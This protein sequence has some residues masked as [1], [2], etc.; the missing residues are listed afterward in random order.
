MTPLP[1]IR[2]FIV[3]GAR[4][5]AGLTPVTSE[6]VRAL[7]RI[8]VRAVGMKPVARGIIA[9]G[10]RWQ[11]D[12]L[13]QLAAAS[14]FGLPTRVLCSH[15]RRPDEPVPA[16]PDAPPTLDTVVD[17]FRVLSTWADTVVVDGADGLSFGA[18]DLARALALPF[19]FVVG[20][21]SGSSDAAVTEANALL[22]GG[23]EC[24]GWLGDPAAVVH[25]H[26]PSG[27]LGALMPGEWLSRL[28]RCGGLGH[29]AST[30]APDLSRVRSAL[31]VRS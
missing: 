17:T 13:Q 1:L 22:R 10:G 26:A 19:V 5:G 20:N 15:L 23:V 8:G 9:A 2:S 27:A 21:E 25:Q 7:R 31:S 29:P 11:S 14:A 30:Q 24:S 12:E 4:N 3:L 16:V 18:P 28:P 6:I